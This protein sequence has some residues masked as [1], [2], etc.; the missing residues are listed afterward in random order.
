MINLQLGLTWDQ[1][2]WQKGKACTS[3]QSKLTQS[4]SGKGAKIFGIFQ[5]L[6]LNKGEGG[7]TAAVLNFCVILVNI[8]LF[9]LPPSLRMVI[10]TEGFE[11]EKQGFGN[12]TCLFSIEICV[13][14]N[15]AKTKDIGK[16]LYSCVTA[17]HETFQ[18]TF[19]SQYPA[20]LP[21]S[22]QICMMCTS[23]LQTK[24]K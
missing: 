14:N 5:D 24:M 4:W 12:H 15:D 21:N 9:F 23:A 8:F 7:S 19:L 6:V 20:S 13:E 1:I 11:K 10:G 17:F 3:E 22:F 16:T 18:Y 2:D